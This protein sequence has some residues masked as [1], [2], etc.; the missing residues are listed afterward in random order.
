MQRT[1]SWVGSARPLS[2]TAWTSCGAC[3]SPSEP[4]HQADCYVQ[5]PELSW[6]ALLRRGRVRSV[7]MHSVMYPAMTHGRASS[8]SHPDDQNWRGFGGESMFEWGA[9]LP[10]ACPAAS[11]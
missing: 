3:P 6:Q 10:C 7:L 4:N 5:E 2:G 11:V 1:S 9:C 8:D